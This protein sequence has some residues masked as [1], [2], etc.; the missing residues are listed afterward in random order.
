MNSQPLVIEQVL[1][2]PVTRVWDALTQNE[3]MKKWYFEL[4]DFKAVPGFEFIFIA[5]AK[6]DVEYK[7]ICKVIEVIP[8]K[9]LSYSWRYDSYPEDSLVTFDL[10]EEGEKTRLKLT[11][12]GL[13]T[14]ASSGPDF[15]P[16]NFAEGWTQI[17]GKSLKEFLQA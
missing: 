13:E 9:K 15:A 10:F 11:H 12:A 2:A 6:G 5:G 3:Q 7:H 1:E 17:V 8:Q 16:D 14:F 4:P